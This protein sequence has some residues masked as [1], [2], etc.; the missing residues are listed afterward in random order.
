MKRIALSGNMI[1]VED[2]RG[3][4]FLVDPATGTSTPSGG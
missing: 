3:R 1:E 4:T 2:L